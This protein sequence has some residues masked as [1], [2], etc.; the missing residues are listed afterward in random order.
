M[1]DLPFG[2]QFGLWLNLPR[3]RLQRGT[4]TA[5]GIQAAL[6]PDDLPGEWFDA[7]ARDEAEAAELEACS[8]YERMRARIASQRG[9]A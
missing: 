7:V 3:V 9:F 5:L 8:N 6:S 2:V 4:E 1:L